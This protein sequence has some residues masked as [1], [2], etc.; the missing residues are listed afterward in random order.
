MPEGISDLISLRFDILRWLYQVHFDNH[1]CDSAGIRT[2]DPSAKRNAQPAE[3]LISDSINARD[4]LDL[5]FLSR[6]IASI[7]VE[8]ISR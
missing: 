8:Y 4:F 7:F 5:I 6:T 3:L 1:K 2:Q